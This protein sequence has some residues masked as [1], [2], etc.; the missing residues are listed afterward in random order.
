MPKVLKILIGIF[1]TGAVLISVYL[2]EIKNEPYEETAYNE[3]IYNYSTP[4][5]EIDQKQASAVW[6]K[7]KFSDDAKF[8]TREK[9]Y[10][11][12]VFVQSYTKGSSAMEWIVVAS[13]IPE[14]VE[15]IKVVIFRLDYQTFNLK[16][17]YYFSYPKGK[18]PTRQQS[19]A[20][21]E[22]EVKKEPGGFQSINESDVV[23]QDGN[24]IYSY[25]DSDIVETYLFNWDE[26]PGN[27]SGRLIEFLEKQYGIG[28]PKFGKSANIEKIENN[29][30]IRV[31]TGVNTVILRLND[32]N[33]EVNLK[34]D[35]GRTDEL[36]ARMENGK[37]NIYGETNIGATIIFNKYAG[38]TIFHATRAVWIAHTRPIKEVSGRLITP[39][40]EINGTR[41]LPRI[42]TR[43]ESISSPAYRGTSTIAGL[44]FVAPDYVPN[45]SEILVD[46]RTE[47]LHTDGSLEPE[48][49]GFNIIPEKK[50]LVLERGN[51]RL[52][53]YSNLTVKTSNASAEGDYF[54]TATARYRGWVV[55]KNV[56]SFK[57]GKGGK[58]SGGKSMTEGSQNIGYSA[59]SPPLNLTENAE[60]A[61]V[62]LRD[63]YLRGRVYKLIGVTSEYLDLENYSGFFAV[64]TVDVG[65]QDYPGEIIRYIVD[66][67]EKKIIGSSAT[68]RAALEYFR[69]EAFDEAKGNFT[70][71]WD[72]WNFPGLWLDPETNAST[73]TLVIDQTSLNNSYRVIDRHSLRYTVS[74]SP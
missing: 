64:A 36:D 29:R 12:T 4:G 67:E 10:S 7:V 33:T 25:L 51:G 54:I 63:P 53:A 58:K 57:I 39:G 68:P 74:L 55:G 38:R 2:H 17:L 40:D 48:P 16:R 59:D 71:R 69:G 18:E 73:E 65:D 30:A 41:Q 49:E 52:V 60:M 15:D 3:T 23:L 45:G 61:E 11:V 8:V 44:S 24:Y 6:E 5:F 62:A 72:A 22:E 70:K 47:M 19:I 32:E 26:I 34:I 1:I 43:V 28:L 31:I 66:R 37:V 50:R 42:E 46:Y 20:A 14:K 9:N 27:D 56:F 21:M 13:S 35:D